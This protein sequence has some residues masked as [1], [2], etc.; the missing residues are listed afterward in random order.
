MHRTA[1][2]RRYRSLVG[3]A[4]A[5]SFSAM[6][7][8]EPSLPPI[9]AAGCRPVPPPPLKDAK[10]RPARLLQVQ[11]VFRHGARTPV[12]DYGCRD[13]CTW[14]PE[15]TDKTALLRQWG[16]ILLLPFACG[17]PL[18]EVFG[19]GRCPRWW[20]RGW[21]SDA[22][23]LQQAGRWRGTAAGTSTR[24]HDLR[25]DSSTVP[26]PAARRVA[27]DRLHTEHRGSGLCTPLP[28]SSTALS[29]STCGRSSSA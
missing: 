21:P 11:T 28:A 3:L 4:A 6:A 1:A 16:R 13:G 20:W 19:P 15:D 7:T 27:G 29:I 17:E 23:R 14:S 5:P 12:E 24:K 18:W 25:R 26:L 8:S 10:G 2:M 22:D 9:S